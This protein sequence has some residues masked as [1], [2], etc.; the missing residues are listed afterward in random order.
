MNNNAQKLLLYTYFASCII[1][2]SCEFW[3]YLHYEVVKIVRF[4]LQIFYSKSHLI[5]WLK[6]DSNTILKL[7]NCW[8]EEF[9]VFSGFPQLWTQF[10]VVISQI[11]K[12][13]W[14]RFIERIKFCFAFYFCQQI[15]NNIL[16]NCFTLYLWEN[17]YDWFR[18][19]YEHFWF[20]WIHTC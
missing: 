12:F 15:T 10:I 17:I 4:H 16:Y 3:H 6:E 18:F 1:C 19:N 2:V 13:L 5:S 20:S 7:S 14:A 9:K 8:S 11:C